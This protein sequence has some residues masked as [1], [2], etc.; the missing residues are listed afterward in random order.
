MLIGDLTGTISL[1][2]KEIDIKKLLFFKGPRKIKR[3]SPKLAANFK[4][5]RV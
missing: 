3:Y 1:K 5:K 4:R 2:I